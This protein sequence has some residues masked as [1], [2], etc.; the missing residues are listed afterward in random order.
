[1]AGRV[2]EVEKNETGL[3]CLTEYSLHFVLTQSTAQ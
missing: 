3:W 1:M 2:K